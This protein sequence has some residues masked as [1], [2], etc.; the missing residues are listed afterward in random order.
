MIT[1]KLIENNLE[2]IIKGLNK[3]ADIIT[4]T[5]GGSGKNVII[6]DNN[7]RLRFTKDGVSVA[8]SIK[9]EDPI[10]NIGATILIS[11]A[12]KTV[13]SCGDGTTL[14]T[15]LSKEL[16]NKLFEY[17]KTEKDINKVLAD[18]DIDLNLIIKTLL[19]NTKKVESLDDIRDIATVSSKDD[20]IGNLIKEI[21]SKTGYNASI[22]LEKGDYLPYTYYDISEGL[23]FNSSWAHSAFITDKN[24]EQCVYNDVYVH[25][26]NSP[27]DRIDST[28]EKLLDN[29]YKEDIPI[30][31]IAPK[32]SDNV[33]R[34]CTMNKLNNGA[35]IVLLK[36]P[37]YAESLN[38]NVEDINSF[39][40]EDGY[41]DKLICTPF[42]YTLYNS[43]TPFKN[44]RIEDLKKLR[45]SAIESYDEVDYIKRIHALEGSACII[46]VGDLNEQARNEQ[47]DRIEDAIGAVK[48]ALELGISE[49]GGY[50]FYTLSNLNYKLPIMSEILKAPFKKILENANI[51][52]TDKLIDTKSK[53]QLITGTYK[54]AGIIDPTKVL[55][56]ALKNASSLVKLLI[57]TTY[58]LYNE[59]EYKKP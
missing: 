58:T 14:T 36:L 55:I 28:L 15:L 39:L 26:E 42:N 32:F 10:E 5:M 19:E 51:F 44:Q 29:A 33:I 46:Y 4:S 54:D 57:N 37:G 49:G 43:Y 20:S 8:K 30:A 17:I 2:K 53:K 12:D 31:I 1:T 52:T 25:V 48:S 40:N 56:E 45:D 41:I 27:I 3:A 9:F 47:Y 59:N 23:E 24:T 34:M 13:K 50:E 35:K 11:A 6:A 38:R 7:E 16:S 21:Y 22:K 18:L